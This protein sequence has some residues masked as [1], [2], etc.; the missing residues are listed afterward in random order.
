[1][2]KINSINNA[3]SE[4]TIDPDSGDSVVTYA[5][6]GVT[7]FQTYVDSTDDSYRISDGTTD[8]FVVK[9]TGETTKPKQPAFLAVLESDEAFSSGTFRIGS[10]TS[11]TEIF[12]Q[13]GDF[14][15]NGQFTAP[16][17][18]VYMCGCSVTGTTYAT[19]S[20]VIM[21]INGSVYISA[22]KWPLKDDFNRYL[23]VG[24]SLIKYMDAADVFSLSIDSNASIT[25]YGTATGTS[26]Y[27]YMYAY[28]VM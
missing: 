15:T 27:T 24:A 16:I 1:M 17:D 5:I 11:F 12:D 3:A 7:K 19:S 21:A 2:G 26:N 8:Y 6:G 18:G 22:C 9:P 20:R 13:S 25:I 14:N 23:G 4:F 10:T 28:L